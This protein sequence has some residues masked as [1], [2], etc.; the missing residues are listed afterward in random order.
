M[1][2]YSAKGKKNPDDD[3]Y[4]TLFIP[5]NH[6]P[7]FGTP[8][9]GLEIYKAIESVTGK[10]DK[11]ECV[12]K[13]GGMWR[14]TLKDNKSRSALLTNGI[15]VRGHSVTVL[16]KNPYLSA[17]GEETIRLKINNLPYS[18]S[19]ETVKSKLRSL[20]VEVCGEVEWEL[21]KDD[22]KLTSCK[23]G[24]RFIKIAP[25]KVT[26]PKSVTIADKF[27]AYL[28]YKG[29]DEDRAKAS[30]PI[31]I[32][33]RVMASTPIRPVRQGPLDD[34]SSSLSSS[35]SSSP[36][37]SQPMSPFEFGNDDQRGRPTLFNFIL[38]DA[39]KKRKQR[40][41]N[42]DKQN[43]IPC[44]N[45]Y[46][47]LEAVSDS[48]DDDSITSLKRPF[49]QNECNLNMDK[50]NHE[51][52]L[53]PGELPHED[54]EPGQQKEK[55]TSLFQKDWW[56]FENASGKNGS[57]SGEGYVITQ[58]GSVSHDA[59]P[60]RSTQTLTPNKS[61]PIVLPPN[62]SAPSV[63]PPN[64]SAPSDLPQNMSAPN[65]LPPTNITAQA[66]TPPPKPQ[67]KGRPIKLDRNQLTLDDMA[68]RG[69]KMS[70]T[71][72]SKTSKRADS[73]RR[74]RGESPETSGN[75]RRKSRYTPPMDT[76]KQT[77]ASIDNSVGDPNISNMPEHNIRPDDTS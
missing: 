75:K 2:A 69:R 11:S 23:T 36:S 76:P 49:Q 30:T 57:E 16:G 38:Q 37:P 24:S 28:S 44:H 7:E 29:Q 67:R 50:N 72:R 13:I 9:Y 53:E 48:D 74:D 61:A 63:L 58:S 6:I 25:P 10:C 14:V 65:D 42:Q 62:M 51:E 15:N 18:V 4:P 1:A 64:M 31:P 59:P 17:D 73:K 54:C 66:R 71:S 12:Q 56:D 77:T 26:V 41:D 45:I 32:K 5:K 34:P 46:E 19:N 33:D 35:P 20:G 21:Y 43:G 60:P 22:K 70:R 39:W 8:V 3:T 27:I 68:N 40:L 52:E 47:G 55:E